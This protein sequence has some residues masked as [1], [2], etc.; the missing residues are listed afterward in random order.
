MWDQ[1][2]GEQVRGCVWSEGEG[3]SRESGGEIEQFRAAVLHLVG[4]LLFP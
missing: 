3:V 2:C 1:R 4:E